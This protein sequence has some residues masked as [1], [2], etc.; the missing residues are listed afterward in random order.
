MTNK[1]AIQAA[2]E[3]LQDAKALA[4]ILGETAV[5]HDVI[6]LPIMLKK[7][8]DD[9]DNATALLTAPQPEPSEDEKLVREVFG[10]LASRF[11]V[12]YKG[13]EAMDAFNRLM[14][15][16]AAPEWHGKLK[17]VLLLRDGTMYGPFDNRN[18]AIEWCKNRQEEASVFS[19]YDIKAPDILTELPQPPES[20]G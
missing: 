11:G 6:E 7:N 2:V 9:I 14:Q 19:T 20:E 13:K 10:V 12:T 15:Q 5:K 4:Q 3:A 17:T 18:S 1:E 8:L 16:R